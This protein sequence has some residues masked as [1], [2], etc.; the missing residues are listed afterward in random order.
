M[1]AN[2]SPVNSSR[3]PRADNRDFTSCGKKGMMKSKCAMNSACACRKIARPSVD[4]R[5]FFVAPY[6]RTALEAAGQAGNHQ[7][8]HFGREQK[9]YF[10]G[11]INIVTDVDKACERMIL[12]ILRRKFPEHDY[13]TEETDIAQ[14]GKDFRWIIDPLDGT[15]N[16]AHGYPF[17]SVSIALEFQGR[18]LL[19]VV[20]TPY[21]GELFYAAEDRGAWLMRDNTRKRKRLRVSRI[22]DL[23]KSLLVTG[24]PYSVREESRPHFAMFENFILS[25]QGVRRDG[26]ASLNL[27]YIAAGRFDG[28]WELNLHPWDTAAGQL[29][30][31]EAGGFCTDFE[32]KA[33]V[34]AMRQIVSSNGQLHKPMLETISTALK[35]CKKQ[36]DTIPN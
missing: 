29:A 36:G 13:V 31:K 2:F 23:E 24:F 8:R 19:G 15:T 35:S 7:L 14:T 18:I 34:P 9:I 4:K 10:K 21:F 22:A 3:Q 5:R 11:A 32:G 12:K 6:L 20:Y 16:Y 27:C 17:F 28:F 30:V 33:F 25:A 1:R 26:C